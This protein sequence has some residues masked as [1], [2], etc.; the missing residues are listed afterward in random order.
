ME[1]LKKTLEEND[2]VGTFDALEALTSPTGIIVQIA[3]EVGL[4]S[5]DATRRIVMG[6]LAGVQLT[7]RLI[8]AQ[9]QQDVPPAAQARA[10]AA[11]PAAV[12]AM[13]RAAGQ[14]EEAFAATRF[15]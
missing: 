14:L 10:R 3:D 9:M 7:L 6:I 5:N 15:K 13:E 4:I 1:K 2:N 12:S 11:R 8:A